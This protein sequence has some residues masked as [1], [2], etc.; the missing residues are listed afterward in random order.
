M[1]RVLLSCCLVVDAQHLEVDRDRIQIDGVSFYTSAF[2][3]ASFDISDDRDPEFDL[4]NLFH[5]NSIQTLGWLPVIGAETELVSATSGGYKV[6]AVGKNAGVAG[7]T[8]SSATP[9]K[10]HRHESMIRPM[11]ESSI[12]RPV[13]GNNTSPINGRTGGGGAVSTNCV[14]EMRTTSI[15]LDMEVVMCIEFDSWEV[16]NAGTFNTL[17]VGAEADVAFVVAEYESERDR[18]NVSG[19]LPRGLHFD[20]P[21]LDSFD[22]VQQTCVGLQSLQYYGVGWF[23]GRS[24]TEI[25]LSTFARY[26]GSTFTVDNVTTPIVDD[27]LKGVFRARLTA[28]G[29]EVPYTSFA[30]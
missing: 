6:S 4:G 24:S 16:E 29:Y 30:R 9:Y 17:R 20:V 5:G 12:T 25:P 10:I 2:A 18:W 8:V 27:C 23:Q 1:K 14:C 11:H 3:Q 13:P 19:L 21:F 15:N 28:Y 7:L 26:T 22:V